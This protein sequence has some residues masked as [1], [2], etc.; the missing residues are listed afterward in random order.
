[1]QGGQP[2]V[3]A[4]PPEF[5][6]QPDQPLL[7]SDL[8]ETPSDWRGDTL[9]FQAPGTGTGYDLWALDVGTGERRPVA[10]GG[11]NESDARWSPDGRWIAY[12]SD[13]AGRPDIFVQRWPAAGGAL[14]VTLAGGTRPR[15]RRDG[16]ALFFL[17][18]GRVMR[19][20]IEERGSRVSFGA[21][22]PI[23]DVPGA[24]DYTPANRSDRLL[25][26]VPLARA[27]S[28]RA[29]IIVEWMGESEIR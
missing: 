4:R 21:A 6:A 28:A 23:A 11:F 19:S 15:W 5:S 10:R 18:D 16:R 25:A 12:V 14:R 29:R 9:L 1:M 22:S 3:F 2:N 27:E 26:I 24:R 7:R 8:D 20:E 13:E 17:R